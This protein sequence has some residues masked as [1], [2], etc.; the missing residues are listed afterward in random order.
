MLPS[1]STTSQCSAN[2]FTAAGGG[3]NDNS[4]ASE[5]SFGSRKVCIEKLDK[6]LLLKCLYDH[7]QGK[8]DILPKKTAFTMQL[9]KEMSI[10]VA[11]EHIAKRQTEDK[12]ST[13][14]YFDYVD[15]K[16]IKANIGGDFMDT[17]RYDQYHGVGTARIAI[18][19][20]RVMD[21][22]QNITE[23]NQQVNLNQVLQEYDNLTQTR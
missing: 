2:V 16:P 9:P 12:E 5:S 11:K 6:A 17:R 4:G 15:C 21:C 20:A 23:G 19:Y 22:C 14:L 8:G 1:E 3:K 18:A 7:G 10:D 13:T